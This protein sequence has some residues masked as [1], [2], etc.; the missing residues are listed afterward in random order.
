M[1]PKKTKYR[2]SHKKIINYSKKFQHKLDKKKININKGTFAIQT[3][4][5]AIITNNQI[6]TIKLLI[7]RKLKKKG[8]FWLNI[9][10]HQPIT[11]KPLETRMG[12]GKGNV[13]KWIQVIKAGQTF[14]EFEGM[15]ETSAKNVLKKIKQKL[16]LS[17]KLIKKRQI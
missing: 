16:P 6:D 2:K 12:K 11:K 1:K 9:F 10:P 4:T 5:S 15:S 13:Y 7:T 14:I 8:Q 17:C 3:K